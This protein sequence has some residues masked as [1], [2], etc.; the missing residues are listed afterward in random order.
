MKTSI[1]TTAAA[2]FYKKSVTRDRLPCT[3]ITGLH[4]LKLQTGASWRYRY[5][6]T[7]GKRRVATVGGYPAL[8]PVEAAA[9]VAEWI[10]KDADPLLE[11]KTGREKA[12]SAEEAKKIKTL[13]YYLD[14]RYLKIME[15]WP[16]RSAQLNKQRLEL[17]FKDLLNTPMDE[18]TKRHIDQWQTT[19]EKKGRAH[20]TIKRVYTSLKALLRQA[21]ADKVISS[22]PLKGCQLI[23]PT[24]TEQAAIKKRGEEL[25]Q[26]RRMLTDAETVAL[27]HGLDKFGEEI[28]QQRRNSRAHGKP[29][30][31][32]L[33][34]VAYPH[35]FIPFCLLALHTGLRPGDLYTLTWQELNINFAKLKKTTGKS[36]QSVRR[37]KGGTLVEMKL[38]NRIHAIMKDW[39]EQHGKPATGL[40][41]PSTVTGG[42]FAL[43]AHHKPWA[44]VK[45]ISGLP[46]NLNFYALRHNFISALVAQGLPLLAVAKLAGHKSTAMIEQH[47]GHLCEKQAAE[48]VDIMADQI[49]RAVKRNK[50]G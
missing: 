42:Q 27:H 15:T 16:P 48:A 3:K 32:D 35:W 29:N 39:W 36:A 9:K 20:N 1:T 22:D 18:I 31:P 7:T 21:V 6:D 11:K 41:F 17:H 26:K 47:Y 2:K 13:G 50:E 25:D 30:L 12:I 34:A 37:G 8:T 28:R 5:T 45:K 19:Q 33:D 43:T 23:N 10:A 4:L 24:F 38:N 44:S 14:G 40:V 46:E 49:R